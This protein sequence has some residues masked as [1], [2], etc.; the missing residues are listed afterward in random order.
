MFANCRLGAVCHYVK[1]VDL[2][3]RTDLAS[4]PI[5]RR[6]GLRA[7]QAGQHRAWRRRDRTELAG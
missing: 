7:P 2:E 4:R 3:E 6:S 1:D 5:T